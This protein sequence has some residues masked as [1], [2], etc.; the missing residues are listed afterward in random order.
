MK[1]IRLLTITINLLFAV[2]YSQ[3]TVEGKIIDETGVAISGANIYIKSSD[4]GSIS[5]SDGNYKLDSLPQGESVLVVDFIGYKKSENILTISSDETITINITLTTSVLSGQE[6]VV[7]GYGT[8]QRRE[9]T[10]SISRI[11]DLALRDA[12]T[13]GFEEALQGN[14]SGVDVQEYSGEPGAAP[15][16][17]IR[18]AGSISA[19]NEPLYVVNGFPIS[20]N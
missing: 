7:V 1:I 16:I 14:V 2:L 3:G 20:K 12:R 5:D 18:G 11:S 17:R 15:N 9:V 4:I 13:L 6:V 10:G 8:Q 19:G